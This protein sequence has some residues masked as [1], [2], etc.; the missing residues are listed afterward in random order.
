MKKKFL[1]GLIALLS[2][3]FIFFGCGGDSGT[4]GQQTDLEKAVD[5]LVAS[6]TDLDFEG[7][8]F[9]NS[10]GEVTLG[11]GGTIPAA[12]TLSIPEG[13]T[14][15]L[16]TSETL[17]IP[18][19][20]KIEIDGALTIEGTLTPTAG[21]QLVIGSGVT[22]SAV[23][24]VTFYAYNGTAG[25]AAGTTY[26]WTADSKW[27]APATVLDLAV[28]SLAEEF[29][30]ADIDLVTG[31]VTLGQK[32]TIST[33]LTVP[34]GVT[35]TVNS[36]IEIAENLEVSG[37]FKLGSTASGTNT[38]TITVKNG[39]VSTSE[40]GALSG[41]AH[42]VVESGGQ[43]YFWGGAPVL[44]VG[45]T[46]DT[47]AILQ[48]TEGT[49]TTTA[50]SPSLYVLDGTAQVNGIVG[51]YSDPSYSTKGFYAI[52]TGTKVTVKADSELTVAA[53]TVLYLRAEDAQ[54]LEGEP[55]ATIVFLEGAILWGPEPEDFEL[56]FYDAEGT[57]LAPEYDGYLGKYVYPLADDA[58]TTFAWDTNA[59][60]EGT[61]GWKAAAA[62]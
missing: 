61:A 20:G 60:G 7:V 47:T 62:E 52:Q 22:A 42:T 34:V 13:V 17:I 19:D 12:E 39:G 15:I 40:G 38:G 29:T 23:D 5:E 58:D 46:A 2:V 8:T 43:V 45:G 26:T 16:P 44:M 57:I 6:L 32:E 21:A 54:L 59:D 51:G 4:S 9:V 24:G 35:L 1:F 48:L 53:T 37:T 25:L 28:E 56:N 3:S 50:G 30:G 55:G 31:T 36:E 33:A 10:T 14:L 49:L 18:A 41:A 11:E 27:K